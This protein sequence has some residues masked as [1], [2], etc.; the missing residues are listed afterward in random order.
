MNLHEWFPST[1]QAMSPS[2][3]YIQAVLKTEN[4]KVNHDVL[5]EVN[6]TSP[7]KYLSYEVLGRGDILTAESIYAG[8]KNIVSFR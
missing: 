3:T 8:D 2:K 7:L 1:N 4:P 5:I 6:S